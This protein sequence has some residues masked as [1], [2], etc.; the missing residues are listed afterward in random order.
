YRRLSNEKEGR[1]PGPPF[2]RVLRERR[3]YLG[4]FLHS[5]SRS[6]T[7]FL[8]PQPLPGL[9]W[10]VSALLPLPPP[11]PL[12]MT[13]AVPALTA[14]PSTSIS[15]TN[16]DRI[17]CCLP[18]LGFRGRNARAAV[19]SFSSSSSRALSSVLCAD[20]RASTSWRSSGR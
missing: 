14:R 12:A 19:R 5:S 7:W 2:L 10:L 6:W 16:L 8:S 18:Y 17:R 11:L 20:S 4:G 1:S 3:A 9:Y 15:V 13:P